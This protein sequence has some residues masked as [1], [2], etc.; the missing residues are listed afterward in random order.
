MTTAG[1]FVAGLIAGVFLAVLG[2]LLVLLAMALGDDMLWNG[3]MG[4]GDDRG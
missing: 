1:I 4:R 2:G 3:E